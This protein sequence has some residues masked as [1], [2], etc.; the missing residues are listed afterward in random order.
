MPDRNG[1]LNEN[2]YRFKDIYTTDVGDLGIKP[3]YT[4]DGTEQLRLNITDGAHRYCALTDA[5]EEK[6]R[7]DKEE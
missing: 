5:Y 6:L 1:L 2:N 7:K 4:T 3:I